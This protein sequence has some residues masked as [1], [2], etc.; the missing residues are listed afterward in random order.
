MAEFALR[1]EIGSIKVPCWSHRKQLTT[2]RCV[3]ADA[4]AHA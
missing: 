4:A 1:A 2:N 3:E